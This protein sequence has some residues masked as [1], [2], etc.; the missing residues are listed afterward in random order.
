MTISLSPLFRFPLDKANAD[1]PA[2][3]EWL[4]FTTSPLLLR[5]AFAVFR[6][7]ASLSSTENT[8]PLRHVQISSVNLNIIIPIVRRR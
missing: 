1:L 8:K 6:R 2:A 5:S 3:F 7:F 4:E